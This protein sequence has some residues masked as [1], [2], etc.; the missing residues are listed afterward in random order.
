MRKDLTIWLLLL[1]LCMLAC[2][3]ELHFP[4]VPSEGSL[5]KD[6]GGDCLPKSIQG[7]YIKGES[8][9][10]SSIIVD[11]DIS[12]IGAYRIYSDTV[13]GYYFEAS[14]DFTSTGI[15]HVEL[16][17]SGKPV[18]AGNDQFHIRYNN[19]NCVIVITVETSS[20]SA[21]TAVFTFD[22][23]PN[24]CNAEVSGAYLP[25][26]ALAASNTV[27][28]SVNVSTAGSYSISTTTVNGISFS[29]SGIF[30]ATGVNTIILNG[31][32]TPLSAGTINLPLS[33]GTSECSFDVAVG[34]TA[35]YTVA[36]SSTHVEGTITEGVPLDGSN[37]ITFA[38]EATVAGTYSIS[39]NEIN[40][41]AFTGTGTLILGLNSLTLSG[42]GTPRN[43]GT[44]TIP[45]PIGTDGC[46]AEVTVVQGVLADWE[47]TADIAPN[48]KLYQGTIN[49]AAQ[50]M[51]NNQAILKMTGKT[52]DGKCDFT[53]T[54]SNTEGVI[55]T[56]IY[57][58]TSNFGKFA[59]FSLQDAGPLFWIAMPTF[60][61]NLPV[62]LTR[63][64]PVEHYVE[65][66]FSG[67]VSQGFGMSMQINN[68][69]FKAN[70][71]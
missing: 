49:D 38:V 48:I 14:G 33:A 65:G 32:G 42:T 29:G 17:A 13:N 30:S 52:L 24:E 5:Q 64:D 41:M 71:H 58:G 21:N 69:K 6:G 45:V 70:F 8:L 9:S 19:S 31:S 16:R 23:S 44:F 37:T 60:A 15:H 68:G 63:Y 54:I 51:F 25:G 67:F 18:A 40:G 11:A 27:A 2:Q 61:S 43:D 66:T 46:T 26:V 35:A 28:V 36:C 20:S 50:T 7:K 53:L 47:L 62:N 56:G 12:T 59:A 1:S 22:G 57:S 10:S 3:R 4:L 55:T 39:T 34:S